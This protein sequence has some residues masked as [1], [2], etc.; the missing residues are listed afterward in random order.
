MQL[1]ERM[2]QLISLLSKFEGIQSGNFLA[3]HLNVS[4]RTIRND[5]T[6]INNFK[7]EII[8]YNKYFS[9]YLGN[10]KNFTSLVKDVEKKCKLEETLKEIENKKSRKIVYNPI[11]NQD[12]LENYVISHD[13]LLLYCKNIITSHNL[14]KRL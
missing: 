13:T 4:T 1:T 8:G 11:R 14:L 12:K 7:D 2:K 3:E 9:V 10:V 6:S 5:I